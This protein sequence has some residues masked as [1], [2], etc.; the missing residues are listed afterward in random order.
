MKRLWAVAP[1]KNP[2]KCHVKIT[3]FIIPLLL[4]VYTISLPER[5]EF[6]YNRDLVSIDKL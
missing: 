5:I 3:T 6:L 1:Q 4:K 2:I